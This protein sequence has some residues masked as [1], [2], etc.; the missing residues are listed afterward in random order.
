MDLRDF[1]C[2]FRFAGDLLIILAQVIVAIQMVYEEK[3]LEKYNVPALLA[4][5]LEGSFVDAF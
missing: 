2:H 3:Y 4:V 1:L 5:G